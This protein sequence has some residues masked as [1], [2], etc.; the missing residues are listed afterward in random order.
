[1]RPGEAARL[2]WRDIDTKAR[3]IMI[4]SGKTGDAT[5]P[6]SVPIVRAL[7]LARGGVLRKDA[8]PALIFPGCVQMGHR[9]DRRARGNML[10]RAYRTVAADLGIDE[11]TIRMLM[12]HSLS[13]AGVNAGYITKAVMAGGPGLRKAQ[14]AIS[15]R[16][17]TL[18]GGSLR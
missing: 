3:M 18:L 5:I 16:I 12:T 2:E 14:A 13:G 1:M 17:T 9:L 8:N 7:R 4:R 6:M 10:R 11:I 15:R